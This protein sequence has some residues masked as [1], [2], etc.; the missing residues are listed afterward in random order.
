MRLSAQLAT[1]I[2]LASIAGIGVTGVFAMRVSVDNASAQSREILLRDATGIATFVETWTSGQIDALGG[3]TVPFRLGDSR[4]L[5]ENLLGAVLQAM[6]S[7]V[8]VVLVDPDGFRIATPPPEVVDQL[9]AAGDLRPL[10]TPGRSELVVGRLPLSEALEARR[11]QRQD[12]VSLATGY[13]VGE[14]YLPDG[15][16]TP[17]IPLAI[18]GP[19]DENLILGAEITL[20]EVERLLEGQSSPEHGVALLSATG[21]PILGG[22]HPLV[23]PQLLRAAGALIGAESTY[24]E[25]DLAN[26]RGVRGWL[27]TVHSTGWTVV[28]VEPAE[29][30]EATSRDIRR[31]TTQVLVVSILLAVAVGLVVAR[32]LSQ[33]VRELRD[34][35]LAVADGELGRRVDADRQDELG[36]LAK[37]FNHMSGR[38][39]ANAQEIASQQAEIAAFNRE[40]QQRVDERTR[41]LAEAQTRLVESGQLAAVAEL[42]AGMAHELN[43]PLAAILGLAQVLRVRAKGSPE[44]AQIARIEEQAGRCRD[45]VATMLRLST[46]DMDPQAAPVVDLRPVLREVVGLV[47]GP[48]R[49]RGVTL[50]LED[51]E[52]PLRAKVDPVAASRILA[53]ILNS[54]RAGLDEGATLRISAQQ[55]APE[56]GRGRVELCFV[57]DRP[58]AAGSARDDWRASGLGFWVARHLLDQVGGRLYE[59]SEGSLVW[60]ISL[61]EAV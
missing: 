60:R 23:D 58:V 22:G 53:Q 19:R 51:A 15:T 37:A 31:Q 28:V 10:A 38:L 34:S 40:L 43:N 55:G 54:L 33:P 50:D 17:S 59:P 39:A 16:R 2:A 12:G 42:G 29:V 11:L 49:Q 26:G 21:R 56:R 46:G 52:I 36:E 6:P 24:V 44:E 35:A 8:T 3:W 61:P 4:P 48:F 57:P 14:P 13:A 1:V 45:V 47:A 41:D 20:A 27:A 7:V 30:A 18:A 5:Q 9:V 25:Y 32:S